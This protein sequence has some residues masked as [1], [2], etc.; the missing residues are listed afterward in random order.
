MLAAG[1]PEW[2]HDDDDERGHDNDEEEQSSEVE[3]IPVKKKCC[4]G[5]AEIFTI[6]GVRGNRVF[7]AAE[8]IEQEAPCAWR[9]VSWENI[10]NKKGETLLLIKFYCD[11][12]SIIIVLPASWEKDS[13][14]GWNRN[15]NRENREK[16]DRD[17]VKKK[18]VNNVGYRG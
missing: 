12:G 15:I 13:L 6:N 18:T 8:S 7:W 9:N 3:W 14:S 17:K 11:V 16:S 2:N 10:S 4:G 5:R 1:K